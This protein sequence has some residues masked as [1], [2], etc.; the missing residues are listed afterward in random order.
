VNRRK[1]GRTIAALAAV[2]L[3]TWAGWT[4]SHESMPEFRVYDGFWMMLWA[5]VAVILVAPLVWRWPRDRS[6][7]VI[8]LAA[9]VGCF[10]PLAISA[11]RHHMPLMVRVR[12]AWRMAGADLVA[13]AVVVGFACLW[14]ALREWRPKTGS[15]SPE[16]GQPNERRGAEDLSQ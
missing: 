5:T 4:A 12:G 13:P 7:A 6:L 14:L 11:Y 8:V 9:A 2:A 10:L 1:V 16:R 3:F 15:T